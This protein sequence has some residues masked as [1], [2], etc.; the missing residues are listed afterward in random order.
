MPHAGH[1]ICGR[2]CQFRLNTCVGKFI[3]S[4]VGE[5]WPDRQVREIHAQVFNMKWLIENK[6]RLGDDF[7][8]AYMKQFGFDDI[9]AGRKYETMVF[10]AVKDKENQCCPWK[11]D[12]S[13]SVDF[14]AAN[15]ADE[16]TKNH[17]DLCKK[18]SKINKIPIKDI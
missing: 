14:L 18:W 8:Y 6:Y 1:F 5:Y 17:W 10:V 9:G 11:I 15:Q 2:D 4:T 12:A 16:A 7:N 13:Q 3:V